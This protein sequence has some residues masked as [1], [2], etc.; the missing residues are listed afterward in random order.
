LSAGF[1]QVV[2]FLHYRFRVLPVEQQA[3]FTVLTVSSNYSGCFTSHADQGIYPL[4]DLAVE[5]FFAPVGLD[6]ALEDEW[7][8]QRNML[9]EQLFQARWVG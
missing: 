3:L 4:V 1:I 6:T 9:F 8:A 7:L 5:N 2:A